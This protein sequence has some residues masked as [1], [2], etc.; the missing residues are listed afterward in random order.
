MKHFVAL[1]SGG[2]NFRITLTLLKE[3]LKSTDPIRLGLVLNY[4]LFLYEKNIDIS[5]AQKIARTAFSDALENIGK[6]DENSVKIMRQLHDNLCTTAKCNNGAK[7]NTC[8]KM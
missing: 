7:C 6:L 5:R 4:S 2:M 1:S 3:K 8:R